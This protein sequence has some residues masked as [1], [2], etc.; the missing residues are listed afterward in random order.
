MSDTGD[1]P[2]ARGP[3][4]I[5]LS[6]IFEKAKLDE[7]PMMKEIGPLM[8]RTIML[9]QP[10][11]R[12]FASLVC[13]KMILLSH[14]KPDEDILLFIHSPGGSVTAGMAIYD[15]MQTLSC[16]VR[17]LGV[18]QC[19][20]MSSF[21]LAA[22]APGKRYVLPNTQ[23]MMHQPSAGTQG[24]VS[25]MERD[26]NEYKRMKTRMRK[27]YAELLGISNKDCAALMDRDTYI[28]A[29]SAKLLGHVDAIV[30]KVPRL[31]QSLSERE[32]ALIK[33]ETDQHREEL[34]EEPELLEMINRRNSL[35]PVPAND[36]KL[37]RSAVPQIA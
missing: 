2:A 35:R 7:W 12:E 5:S 24:K 11:T 13:Q 6:R 4:G 31:N 18:G 29:L 32:R 26:I 25:D 30:T 1:D 23:I 15:V 27:I 19:A 33:V 20:S 9:D 28:N 3:D 14:Q 22:G 17:T 36:A 10:I 21:L 16:D 8:G 34:L 37:L